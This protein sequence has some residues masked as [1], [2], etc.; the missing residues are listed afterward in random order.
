[1]LRRT[2]LI[3]LISIILVINFVTA[4]GA[5][6]T[7]LNI[8]Y[9][10]GGEDYDGHSLGIEYLRTKNNKNQFGIGFFAKETESGISYP[11]LD[12]SVPHNDYYYAG[13]HVSEELGIYLIYDYQLVKSLS[14]VGKAGI[15]RTEF[16]DVNIS[17]A[18]G[19][20]YKGN[21]EID[22]YAMYELGIAYNLNEKFDLGLSYNNR[23]G[24]VFDLSFKF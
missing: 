7:K 19:W 16:T 21:V 18:T 10:Y 22:H 20:S 24:P 5:A 4:V 9:G 1:M 15:S 3:I 12:Y 8:N 11:E 6:D 14:I 17:R 23:R 2:V 13:T